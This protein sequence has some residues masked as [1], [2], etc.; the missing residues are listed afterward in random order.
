LTL[1]L[2]QIQNLQ[3]PARE[4]FFQNIKSVAEFNKKHFFSNEFFNQVE[5]ELK[6]NL[7]SAMQQVVKSRGRHWLEWLKILK[8]NKILDMA[9]GRR[10]LITTH[11][12]QLRQSYPSDPSRNP[13]DPVV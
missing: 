5:N 6:D 7:N 4:D 12:R 3:G 11:I 8:E 10:K 9:R 13:E 2:E 1:H